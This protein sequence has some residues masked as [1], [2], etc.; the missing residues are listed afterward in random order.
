MV[1]IQENLT[2]PFAGAKFLG[3]KTAMKSIILMTVA[4]LAVLFSSCNTMIGIGRDM[5]MGGEGLETTANKASSSNSSGTSTS[6]GSSA[7]PVY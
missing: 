3:I 6:G 4:A 5:K 1:K 2:I 7:A